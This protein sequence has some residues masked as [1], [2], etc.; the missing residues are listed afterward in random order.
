MKKIT[1]VLVVIIIAYF[2]L[3]SYNKNTSNRTN[4][5]SPEM[6]PTPILQINSQTYFVEI[7]DD[8]Q[9]RS[10]GLMQRNSLPQ[11]AGMLFI[12]PR[13][14]R[15]SFYMKNMLFPIDIV[16]IN[17]NTVVD[18]SENI[19][20]ALTQT[21]TPLYQPKVPVDKV[22]E[23]NAGEAKRVGITTGKKVEIKGL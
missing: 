18:I 19:P 1:F 12:F 2:G 13:K 7:A 8:D 10:K 5:P 3:Q 15:Y 23:I 6:K 14:E 21:Y 16:W 11:N 17:E 4:L 9:E 20:V 22:L